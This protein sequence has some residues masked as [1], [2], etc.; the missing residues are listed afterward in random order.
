MPFNPLLRHLNA[1][2]PNAFTPFNL[3]VLYE[4]HIDMLSAAVD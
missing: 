2:Y 4:L 1:L 3:N